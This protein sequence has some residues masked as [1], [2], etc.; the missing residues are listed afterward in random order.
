[1]TAPSASTSLLIGSGDSRQGLWRIGFDPASG[2]LAAPD[3]LREGNDLPFLVAGEQP[4]T[5]L[6]VSEAGNAVLALA[7]DP[8]TGRVVTL[9]RRPTPAAP[10]H[11]ARHRAGRAAF[12]ACYAG[13]SAVSYPVSHDNRFPP[14]SAQFD[15]AGHGPNRSRQD[16]P[17][18]HSVTLSAD[19]RFAYVCDLGRDRIEVHP[20][21]ADTGMLEPARV[22]PGC[23]APGAGPRH[24]AATADGRF[25]YVVNELDNTV[26]RFAR[27]IDSGELTPAESVSTLPTDFA[28][29]SLAS[30]LQ[31]HPRGERFL[32][33][34][35]RGHDSIVIFARDPA[36]GRLK[37]LDHVETGGGHPRHF[38]ISP[39]GRWLACANRHAN[40]VRLFAIAPVTGLLLP[41]PYCV[42]VP[43]PCCVLFGA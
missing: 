39:D 13:A 17:H 43:D 33:V 42:S 14:A 31:L 7:T 38:C 1:M 5:F 4:G 30:E 25:L 40:E 20:L 24:A 9:D 18:P 36:T 19:D 34:A 29:D 22:Q 2:A 28:G 26:T 32:Y 10:C 27:D 41:T 6:A 3:C 23:T 8:A 12:V 21:N 35:N 15:Y 16:A 11:I 37:L